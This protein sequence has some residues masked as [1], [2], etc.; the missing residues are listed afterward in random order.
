M[1]NSICILAGGGLD[2]SVLLAET[3]ASGRYKKVFPA[4]L[5]S[6]FRWENAEL[7]WL[8]KF[9][10]AVKSS[11]IQPLIVLQCPMSDVLKNHWAVTGKSVPGSDSADSSVYLP[12]RNVIL[13]ATTAV[14]CAQ[15]RISEIAIGTLAGNPFPDATAA[16]F[17]S[18]AAVLGV[19]LKTDIMISSP[20]IFLSKEEVMRRGRRFPLELTFSCINPRGR[21]PCRRCNKC[22]ERKRASPR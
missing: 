22:A 14:F 2:S 8:K 15:N 3:A 17:Q 6:G 9:I 13:M 1:R 20:Y 12:G 4:Y 16:F 18:L 7:F 21:N 5:K 11:A 10:A 19:A